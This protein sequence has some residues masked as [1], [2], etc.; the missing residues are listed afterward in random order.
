MENCNRCDVPMVRGFAM[1]PVWGRLD[2]KPS[3]RG[4]TLNMV[5]SAF[6]PCQKCPDCGHSTY[7]KETMERLTR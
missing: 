5:G 2:G 6:G 4:D 3:K 7:T 1:L